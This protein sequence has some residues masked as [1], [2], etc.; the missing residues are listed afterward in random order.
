MLGIL[1]S[2]LAGVFITLQGVFNARVSSKIG[3]LETTVIV[4]AVGLA[5]A[6]VAMFIWGNGSFRRLG[7]VNKIY[8]MGGAFGVIIIYSVIKGFTLLGP[9]YSIAILLVTQL[10]TA[11][12]IDSFGLFG[13]QQ[14]EFD[15]TKP[16]GILIMIIGIVVFKLRG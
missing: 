12:V 11:T 9:T 8:L 6:C 14:I 10:I 2:F 7:E 3:Q 13:T 4:H 1:Y 5:F 15:I 16:L